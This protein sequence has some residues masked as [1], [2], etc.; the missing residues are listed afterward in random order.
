M[1]QVSARTPLA[2]ARCARRGSEGRVNFEVIPVGSFAAN[3][4]IAWCDP[5]AAWIFDPG[6]DAQEL[7]DFLRARE[8]TPG[9]IVLTHGHFDHIGALGDLLDAHPG[10]PVYLNEKDE[11]LAFSPLNCYAEYAAT[12]RPATMRFLPADGA[13]LALGGLTARIVETPGHTPGSTCYLFEDDALLIAGDTLF[14]GSCGR[15]DLPMGDARAMSESLRR[16]R[17][18][19]DA[20]RV[21][22]GHGP[23]TTLATEKR[24]NPYLTV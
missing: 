2:F 1:R 4:T 24:T 5:A 21:I 7:I 22:C 11:L 15:T 10:L 8:L 23:E 18:L 19:P 16:L 14:R 3:C 13:Q 12:K 9:A 6:A 20:L 17:G